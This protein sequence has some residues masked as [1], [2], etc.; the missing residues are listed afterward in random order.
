MDIFKKLVRLEKSADA[1]GFS[2]ETA[3]QIKE[4]IESELLEIKAHLN[5]TDTSKLQEEMGDL[6]HAAFSL[7]IF[8][9]L[10]PQITL[11]NSID[12]F[13]RRFEAV[14]TL[15]KQDNLHS[16]Q[17]KTFEELMSYWKKAKKLV[18]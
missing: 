5:D 17:G 10:D 4:Q 15:S 14:K 7:C 12:K 6:L 11:T 18:G 2:W 13:E 3:D 1:F 16:L 9:H 8:C